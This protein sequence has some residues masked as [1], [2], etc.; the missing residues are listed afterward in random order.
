MG[1]KGLNMDNM[2]A[3]VN[4]AILNANRRNGKNY[5]DSL[6]PFAEELFIRKEYE[7]VT[8]D[9]I[10]QDF[11]SE[12]LFRIPIYPMKV[13]LKRLVREGKVSYCRNNV[14]KRGKIVEKA[15]LAT[16]K[17]YESGYKKVL[18]AFV[19]FMKNEFN[20][21]IEEQDANDALI[22]FLEKQDAS[23]LFF[24]KKDLELFPKVKFERKLIKR[25][26]V[27]LEKESKT[28]SD[29]FKYVVEVASGHILASTIVNEEKQLHE[30]KI[31]KIKIYCD[32]SHVL[33][34]L[35]LAGDV[36]QRMVEDLFHVFIESKCQLL[37]FKHTHDEILSNINNAKKWFKNPDCDFIKASRTTL[38]FIENNF[39]ELDVDRVL[40]NVD[41]Q[42]RKF[43]IQIEDSEYKSDEH[44]GQTGEDKLREY[45]VKEYKTSQEGFGKDFDENINK[46]LLDNDVRSITMVY[47]K[48]RS[49]FPQRFKDLKIV[50]MCSNSSLAKACRTYHLA[51]E[52]PERENFIP[53]CVTD[54]FLGT[55]MWLQSPQEIDRL[56]KRVIIA[57]VYSVLKPTDAMIRKYL[58]EVQ[59]D[60]KRQE[61]TEDDYLLL[62]AGSVI[63]ELLPE[64][65]DTVEQVTKKTPLDI[66]DRIKSQ[67]KEEG[68]RKYYEERD[69]RKKVEEELAREKENRI[70]RKT[71]KKNN[72]AKI[73]SS[74]FDYSITAFI[75]LVLFVT[76]LFSNISTSVI[77]GLI[78]SIS[79]WGFARGHNFYESWKN[80]V[81]NPFVEKIFQKF[82]DDL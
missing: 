13:V 71:K 76:S 46:R 6:V 81:I 29:I 4:F 27:F 43:N 40:N 50:F 42:L 30:E 1:E 5:L 31:Q 53:I 14:W 12:F 67:S 60:Y 11:F 26:A 79:F 3:L 8:I 69:S 62:R 39:T 51:V 68:L 56:A 25:L 35:G 19:L 34:L 33:K 47:R 78:G 2:R 44:V 23:L 28:D 15:I 77:I 9:R 16:R 20:E 7:E 10:C 75:F 17:E 52:E 45:I 59:S 18:E 72:V 32:T 37:L 21:A 22:A 24:A 82:W 66:L 38:Y 58:S 61:I 41:G 64:S 54:T 49:S 55:Y 63:D 48:V 70:A 74:I 65:A 73:I 57:E 80:K 36:P